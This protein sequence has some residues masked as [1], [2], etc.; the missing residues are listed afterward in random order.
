MFHIGNTQILTPEIEVLQ[1]LKTQLAINGIQLFDKFI[2]TDNHIQFNCPSHKNGQER[3]PSCGITKNDI[4]QDLGNGKRK[5]VEAGTVHCFQCGYTTSLPEMISDC[6]GKNDGG[7]FGIKWLTENFI[8]QSIEN[9]KPIEVNFT[10]NTKVQ[11]K[12]QPNYISEEELDSYRYIHPY[13]YKRKLTDEVIEMFD[14]GYDKDFV[15]KDSKTNYETH[16]G[17]CIT[18][19]VRDI[20]GNTLFIARRCINNKTFHYPKDAIKPVYGI[21]EL[22]QLESFP[23]KIIICESIINAL[24]C[25][26]YGKPAV[27]LNGTGTPY[28]MEQ[29]KSLP[30][31]NF[32]TALD[33]DDAGYKGTQKI[34]NALGNSKFLTSY[35]IPKGKDVN[36]LSKE[37]FDNLIETSLI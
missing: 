3:K 29:L 23:K 36:D 34:Y 25:Y 12:T 21:Y 22:Y 26:S 7:L 6:F 35:I 24:T 8:T 10:R 13:M 37:E 4:I 11:P 1:E 15:I 31:R 17:E 5:V 18:F 19:P 30:C 32:V 14:V 27:A 28:Q 16:L 33:P 9:R 2:E 20:N